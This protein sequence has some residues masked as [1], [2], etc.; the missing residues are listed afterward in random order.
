[1]TTI[2]ARGKRCPVPLAMAKVRIEEAD[3]GEVLILLVTDPEAPLDV[4]AWALD[5]GHRLEVSVWEDW[6]EIRLTRGR[7]R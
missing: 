5:E 6:T 7:A 2:D 4:G 1:M 3:P